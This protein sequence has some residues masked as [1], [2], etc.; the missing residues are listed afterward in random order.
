MNKI[1]EYIIP[2]LNLISGNVYDRK[3]LI[4]LGIIMGLIFL[5]DS[6]SI[7]HF[8]T[9]ILFVIFAFISWT[10]SLRYIFKK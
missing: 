3:G 9:K 7:N 8:N 5:Y 2:L 4:F 1:R 10:L 6:F